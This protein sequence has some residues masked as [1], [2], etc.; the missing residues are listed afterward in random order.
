MN[1]RTTSSYDAGLIAEWQARLFLRLYGFKILKSRYIT[2]RHTGRAEIDIIA[3]RGNLIIFCEV[4]KRE[5]IEKALD[6]VT[7]AQSIRLRKAAENYIS[8]VRWMGDARFDII[9]ICNNKV[10]W[11]KNVI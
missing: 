1:I 9:A 3:R 8:S 4:K 2:G 6:A 7:Y 10:H 11:I 5:C